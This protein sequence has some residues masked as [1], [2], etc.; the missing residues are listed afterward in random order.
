M[1]AK[2]DEANLRKLANERERRQNELKNNNPEENRK[3]W[4]ER[5]AYWQ[6]IHERCCGIKK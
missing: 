4:D 2:R 6:S 1:K 5:N 3:E